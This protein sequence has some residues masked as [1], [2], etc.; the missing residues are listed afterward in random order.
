MHEKHGILSF[1]VPSG[2]D[3]SPTDDTD[4]YDRRS[5]GNKFTFRKIKVFR[6]KRGRHSHQDQGQYICVS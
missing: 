5:V 6:Q 1:R 4:F 2:F 3:L